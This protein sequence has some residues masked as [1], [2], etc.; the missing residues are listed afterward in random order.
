MW[1]LL[2]LLLE[3][4]KEKSPKGASLSGVG[5]PKKQSC[6]GCQGAGSAPAGLRGCREGEP[7]PSVPPWGRMG[8]RA[9][10]GGGGTEPS[11]LQVCL[12]WQGAPCPFCRRL[13]SGLLPLVL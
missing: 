12:P 11:A 10:L 7:C 3:G 9:R 5:S 4:L 13:C 8:G 1:Q 6:R 2:L